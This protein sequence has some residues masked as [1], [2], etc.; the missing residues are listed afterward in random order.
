MKT[1]I[2]LGSTSY[3]LRADTETAMQD[4]IA[5][6]T[7][8]HAKHAKTRKASPSRNNGLRIFPPNGENV[9]VKEYCEQYYRANQHIFGGINSFSRETLDFF[10]PL[11]VRRCYA[12]DDYS[13]EVTA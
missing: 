9:S 3:T 4:R 8:L 10:E 12:R 6:V 7:A 13:E 1:V 11:S 5:E 2:K